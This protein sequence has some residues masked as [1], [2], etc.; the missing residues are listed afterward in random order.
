M[1]HHVANIAP[2]RAACRVAD[3]FKPQALHILGF[4]FGT[5]MKVLLQE[6]F[7]QLV[8]E[9]HGMRHMVSLRSGNSCRTDV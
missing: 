7:M 2:G 9:T 8:P 5:H 4:M 1:L 6:M 3:Y